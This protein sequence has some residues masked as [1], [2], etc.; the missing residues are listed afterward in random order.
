MKG[1]N[2][3]SAC[4]AEAEHGGNGTREGTKSGVER[5]ERMKRGRGMYDRD[6]RSRGIEIRIVDVFAIIKP[7]EPFKFWS[8]QVDMSIMIILTTSLRDPSVTSPSECK[9]THRVQM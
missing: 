8:V 1:Y 6:E 5:R 3:H 9:L 7:T 2:I 4:A